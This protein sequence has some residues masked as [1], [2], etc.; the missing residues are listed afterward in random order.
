MFNLYYLNLSENSSKNS[1]LFYYLRNNKVILLFK[2]YVKSLKIFTYFLKDN[3]KN[4]L[5]FY[6][7]KN[8]FLYNI[9][10]NILNEFYIFHYILKFDFAILRNLFLY[11]RALNT[12]K[13]MFKKFFF[14]KNIYLCKIFKY[15]TYFN[16]LNYLNNFNFLFFNYSLFFFFIYIFDKTYFL[17]FIIYKNKY[18]F[19]K[20]LLINI[21]LNIFYN[22][23]YY[24]KKKLIKINKSFLLFEK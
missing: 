11:R 6:I 21:L 13:K 10:I 7:N 20:Y 17:N 8:L 16:I 24:K 2:S 15:F 23:N 18:L 3:N 5:N 12:L 14:I 22:L 1:V 9:Y 19:E 4:F